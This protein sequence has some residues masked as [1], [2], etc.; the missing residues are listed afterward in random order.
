MIEYNHKH[1]HCTLALALTLIGDKYKSLILY[2]LKDGPKRSGELQK[3][4]KDISS[5]MFSYSIRLLEKDKLVRR[6][7]YPEVPPKVEYSLTK[8]GKGLIPI[9]LSLDKW[10]EALVSKRGLRSEKED[11]NKE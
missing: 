7:I 6:T 2:H 8:E 9:L 1:F 5:R 3:E 10:S 11:E 4:I